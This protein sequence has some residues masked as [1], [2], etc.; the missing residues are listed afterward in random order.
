MTFYDATKEKWGYLRE[1]SELALKAGFDKNTGLHRT[2]LDEYLK[3]IFPDIH[4]W[5]HD[6]SIPNLIVNGKRYAKR[7]DYRS[8]QL[9]MIIEFDGLQHYTD[10]VKIKEDREKTEI[11]ESF[12]YKVVRLPYFIQL[13]NDAV[14]VLFN[15]TV[16]E[17]L[18]NENFPSLG[19]GEPATPAY[20]CSAGLIRMAQEFK[21]FPNQYKVNR[22]YLNECND[23]EITG[24]MFLEN[25]Y[26]SL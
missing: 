5:V 17:Y 19:P 11:Y 4:D 21:R 18:F 24:I 12:G 9:K 25:V 2:G 14:K 26:N 6:K 15:V 10:P 23:P 8:E 7:P 13:S 3:V 16:N 20:L 1:T 22:D